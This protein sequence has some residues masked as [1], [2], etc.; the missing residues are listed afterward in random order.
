MTLFEQVVDFQN[1]YRAYNDARKNKRYRSSIL[2]FGYNLE[3]NLISLRRELKNKTY[4]H[5]GYREFVVTDSKRRVIKA[6][7][8]RDRVV[9]HAVCNIIEPIFEKSFIYDS[10]ACRK[11]KGTHAAV[12]R[13]EN[14]IKAVS[15]HEREKESKIVPRLYC[16]KCDISKYFDNIDHKILLGLLQRKIKDENILWLLGEIIKSNPRGIPIGNLT[17]QLF[18][19]IYLNELDH[20]VKR[21]LCERYYVRYMDDFLILSDDKKHLGEVKEIIRK[22]LREWLKL[23]LHPKKAEIFPVDT[24]VDFLGYVLRDGRRFLRKTTVKR[25]MK[26]LQRYKYIDRN[27][28]QEET[29]LRNILASWRGYS[30]WANSS[31]FTSHLNQKIL[32]L[33]MS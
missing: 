8:F 21:K 7:P 10:Y 3:E 11:G 23:E 17:S 13:L 27:N 31:R 18:A 32:R 33:A 30:K 9:H 5:G 15:G 22:F 6:A 29:C 16:L 24:G 1:L 20:F 4:K 26:K 14:F 25:F 19:N 12:K 28:K 2:K